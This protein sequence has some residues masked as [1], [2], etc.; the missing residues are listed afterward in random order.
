MGTVLR[1]VNFISSS[2]ARCGE[3]GWHTNALSIGRSSVLI[4]PGYS[5]KAYENLS[6]IKEE[7]SP[8][9][10]ILTHAHLDHAG[11]LFKAQ[12]IF[13][14][15][16][17][18]ATKQTKDILINSFISKK[19][20]CFD[21]IEKII[22][23]KENDEICLGK[24]IYAEI[25]PAGHIPGSISFFIRAPEGKFLYTGDYSPINRGFI[26]PFS[27]PD[28]EIDILFSEGSMIGY[29]D[30]DINREIDKFIFIIAKAVRSK[31]DV[32]IMANPVSMAQEIIFHLMR[33]PFVEEAAYYTNDVLSGFLDI[34]SAGEKFESIKKMHKN[35]LSSI[36]CLGPVWELL[37]QERY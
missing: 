18:Y 4:D 13:P 16:D 9:S 19:M 30:I 25:L 11:S 23:L 7:M 3:A 33:D 15:A 1:S 22:E 8:D 5:N 14:D 35:G 6:I 34:Y 17:V 32:V 12:E 37:F 28:E 26:K 21:T 31:K 27:L 29:E 36:L 2:G 24:N 20:K 10:I